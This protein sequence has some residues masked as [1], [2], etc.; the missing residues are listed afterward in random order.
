MPRTVDQAELEAD[1]AS[2]HG[3]SQF[4]LVVDEGH[5]SQVSLYQ[6]GPLQQKNPVGP[7]WDGEILVGLLHS[8]DKLSFENLQLMN[9]TFKSRGVN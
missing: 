8:L 3:V 6:E 7:S 5:D 1:F 9:E 2:G 4:G